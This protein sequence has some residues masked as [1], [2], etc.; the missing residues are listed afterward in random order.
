M[1]TTFYTKTDIDSI[2][3]VAGSRIASKVAPDTLKTSLEGLTDTNFLTDAERTK[4]SSLEGSKFLGTYTSV[5]SI[6][7]VDATAGSYADVDE[8]TG[9]DVSRYIWDAD[10]NTFVKQ[11]GSVAGETAASVKTKYESNADTNAFTN[12]LKDKLEALTVASSTTD[13]IAAFDAGMA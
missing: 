11:G 1:P 8:G 5:A 3:G 13:A 6:P 12:T 4:L 7:T 2:M 9:S 10:D